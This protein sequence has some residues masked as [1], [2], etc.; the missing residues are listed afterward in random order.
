MAIFGKESSQQ[1][2][3]QSGLDGNVP[4]RGSLI[5]AKLVLDGKV[6]GQENVVVEGRVRGEIDL[7][8]DL[9]V[10]PRGAI[11]ARVHAKTV[12]VEG[13]VSGDI[14]AD[15]RVELLSTATV[16]GNIRAPSIVV[17]EGAKFRGSVDMSAGRGGDRKGS[18]EQKENEERIH[19]ANRG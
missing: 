19:A 3:P 2:T 18:P 11:E 17:A 5:G 9:R 7:E 8:S 12:T 10:G 13:A 16:E 1:R 6:T 15:N 4:A 14:S